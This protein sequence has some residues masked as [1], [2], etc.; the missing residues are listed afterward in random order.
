MVPIYIK[1]GTA[2][3]YDNVRLD[4]HLTAEKP[5]GVLDYNNINDEISADLN[6]GLIVQITASE[7]YGLSAGPLE[8]PLYIDP[9]YLPGVSQYQAPCPLNSFVMFGYY[10]GS[11]YK[12]LWSTIKQCIASQG[13]SIVC[14]IG[15]SDCVAPLPQADSNTFTH[16][17]LI[18][19]DVDKLIVSLN[20]AI[21]YPKKYYEEELAIDSEERYEHY[22][23]DPDTGQFTKTSNFVNKD[24]LSI[25]EL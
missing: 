5:A 15:N 4:F 6:N 17:D 9:S 7:Y 2:L 21:I 13:V 16:D 8:P 14:R 1:L 24:I 11:W 22:E 10:G 18:G 12:I 19:K 25:Q 23:I 3:Y 20:G